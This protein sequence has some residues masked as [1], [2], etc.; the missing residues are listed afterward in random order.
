MSIK[1]NNSI[2][3]NL[4]LLPE[5]I[6]GWSRDDSIFAKLVEEFKPKCIVEVG[7]WKGHSAIRWAEEIKRNNL[8][9]K[10]YCVDTWLGATE[11]HTNLANSK[12]RNLMM[13][14]GYPQIFYQF[15][16]NVVHRNVQDI[17]IPIP[18]TSIIGYNILRYNKISPDIVYIDASHDYHDVKVDLIN[19]YSLIKR[20]AILVCDDYG[21]GTFPGVKKAV[22]EFCKQNNISETRQI[23]DRK[24]LKKY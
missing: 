21:N 5:D 7:T 17:I 4:E 24:I 10:V 16:S 18:N 2:Y 22:D 23:K 13:K 12:N 8:D 3:D 9:S 11:F 14:N 19:Y 1:L 20:N 15:L 6:V